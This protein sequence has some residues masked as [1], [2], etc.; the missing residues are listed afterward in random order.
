M[1]KGRK[2]DY[3]KYEY[4]HTHDVKRAGFFVL[5]KLEQLFMSAFVF[6]C[7]VFAHDRNIITAYPSL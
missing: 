1:G 2:E 7:F 5:G 6:F 3:R 4:D